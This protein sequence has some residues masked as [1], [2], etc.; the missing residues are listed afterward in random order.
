MKSVSG[1][2]G[3]VAAILVLLLSEAFFSM[4]IFSLFK[5]MM[6]IAVDASS[7]WVGSCILIGCIYVTIIGFGVIGAL[8]DGK[9][10]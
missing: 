4:L 9:K 2:I 8:N 10:G 3:A 6:H 1:Y 5:N 7:L